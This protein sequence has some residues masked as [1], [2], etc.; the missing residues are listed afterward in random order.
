[1]CSACAE[2]SKEYQ[3]ENREWAKAHKICPRC[4]KNRLFGNE[5]TCPECLAD[6]YIRNQQSVARLYGTQHEQYVLRMKQKK[7]QGICRSCGKKAA[8]GHTYCLECLLKRRGR[9]RDYQ[10]ERGNF[11][12]RSERRSYGLCYRCGQ[13][14]DT[15]KGLCS[16]CSESV[17]KNFKGIRST[18]AYWRYDN[19]LLR[20]SNHG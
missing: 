2:Q 15:D 6:S 8:E 5:K 1:M 13:P 17:A 16:K 7:E 11:I 18:N 12:P 10:R 3:R 9:W 19:D 4:M 20:R 14:L